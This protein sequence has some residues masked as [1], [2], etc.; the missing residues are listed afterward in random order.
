MLLNYA[1]EKIETLSI[2]I[3]WNEGW[4]FH[5]FIKI[6]CVIKKYIKFS[7]EILSIAIEWKNCNAI[8]KYDK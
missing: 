3:I 5:T 6:K 8:I 2:I 1:M 4:R 7:F